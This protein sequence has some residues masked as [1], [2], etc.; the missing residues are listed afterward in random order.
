MNIK[1]YF[2]YRPL[3]FK[4]LPGFFKL[5]MNDE[6]PPNTRPANHKFEK[7]NSNQKLHTKESKENLSVDSNVINQSRI[8]EAVG[9]LIKKV[10]SS[11]DPNKVKAICKSQYGI[12]KIDK[13]DFERGDII[14]HKDQLTFQLDYKI[15]HK[16]TL[17]ID[18]QGNIKITLP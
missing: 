1:C 11:I 2:P 13:I 8:A 7:S 3:T 17:F 12:E 6:E 9:D 10:N 18:R 15:S 14:A 4:L 16:L 5:I